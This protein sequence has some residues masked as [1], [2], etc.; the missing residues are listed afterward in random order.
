MVACFQATTAGYALAIFYSDFNV[1][2]AICPGKISLIYG[3]DPNTT[4]AT[5][6]FVEV[7]SDYI[8]HNIS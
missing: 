5:Y 4:V 3:T 8:P 7:V 1:P 2:I 6:T